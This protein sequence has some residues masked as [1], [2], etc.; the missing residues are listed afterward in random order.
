[1]AAE[2]KNEVV[3]E[4]GDKEG[5]KVPF[6]VPM[7]EVVKIGSI[8]NG[9]LDDIILQANGHEAAMQRQFKWISALGLAFSITNS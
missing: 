1:M 7:E 9:N 2:S 4:V 8:E 3:A 6:E 5:P